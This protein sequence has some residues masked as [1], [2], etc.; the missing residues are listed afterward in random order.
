MSKRPDV[1][2]AGA[3]VLRQHKGEQQVILIHRPAY[4]DWS[5][6]KGKG[7]ADELL[8]EVALREVWEETGL[9]CELGLRLGT[10][11]YRVSKGSKHV[12]YWRARVIDEGLFVPGKEVDRI[13]WVNVD[14]AMRKLTYDD[15]RDV[16]TEALEAPETTVLMIVRHGKAMTRKHW[17]GPDRKRRLAA[18]GREQAKAL[19]SLLSAFGISQ[20][21]SSSSTRCVDT[22]KPYA[23]YADVP[24]I[25]VDL[26]SEE[27]G[28]KDPASVQ[29]YLAE[30][31]DHLELPTAV[32]G[33]RP[34]LPS[35]FAGIG[36][37]PRPMVTGEAIAYHLL[38]DGT[39]VN[40]EVFKPT[41]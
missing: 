16:L 28:E 33:H 9:H 3:V 5:L 31:R 41:A 30:V 6:P 4:N 25:A 29:A 40:H 26:L 20:V 1:T 38:A 24:L 32:C 21:I 18:R 7:K 23:K 10:L 8:P 14:K 17:S 37:K 11:K 15:E 34:V 2:A 35:M 36:A 27:E 12:H 22:V 39:I 19:V 13:A